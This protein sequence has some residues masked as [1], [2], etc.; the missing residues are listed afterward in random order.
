MSNGTYFSGGETEVPLLNSSSTLETDLD[1]FPCPEGRGVNIQGRGRSLSYVRAGFCPLPLPQGPTPTPALC[2]TKG[3]TR[4]RK[5]CAPEVRW[6]RGVRGDLRSANQPA[7][8]SRRASERWE[9]KEEEED[10][11]CQEE[12]TS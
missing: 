11:G 6:W 2:L 10:R 5:S 1:C 7:L 8:G 4:V 12:E 9:G 3:E